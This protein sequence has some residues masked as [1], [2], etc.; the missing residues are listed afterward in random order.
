MV[1]LGAL[2]SAGFRAAA[3]W[4]LSEAGPQVGFFVVPRSADT[5]PW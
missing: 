1:A 3:L 4:T 2:R 5:A